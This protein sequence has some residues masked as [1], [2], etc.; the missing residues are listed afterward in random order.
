MART[1]QSAHW[2]TF[3]EQQSD[4]YRQTPQASGDSSGARP[5]AG[6][7]I[8]VAM[9]TSRYRSLLGEGS[10]P[11][12][13]VPQSL[14]LCFLECSYDLPMRIPVMNTSAPPSPTCIAAENT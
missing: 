4:R 8:S 12:A 5:A 13:S 1:A 14:G 2:K 9:P 11:L 10:A 6:H 7:G 3:G